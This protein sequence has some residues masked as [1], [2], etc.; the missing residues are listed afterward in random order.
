MKMT[1]LIMVVAA[2]ALFGTAI[3]TSTDWRSAPRDSAGIAPLP[4][5]EKQ[6][7]VQVYA[8]RAIN[9]R[10]WFAVH[11]W[12]A[13]K[14]KNADHYTVYQVMGWQ[15]YRTGKSARIETDLPDR[16]W[17]GAKPLLVSSLIGPAAESAIPKIKDA[18]KSYAYPEAYRLWPGPN[19]NTYISHIIRSVPEMG[20]ELPPNAIGKDWMGR[21]DIFGP[22]E[23]GTGYQ[24]SLLGALGITIGRA[25]GVEINI[26]GLSFGIDF[27]RPALKLPFVGRIGMTDAP[28]Q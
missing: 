8:A 3:A 7:V 27:M 12:I 21:G 19:S 2:I 20:V 28:V 11:T 4:T 17:F 14:E 18:A 5:V 1:I 25:E 23:T 15:L 13:T 24:L 9:W 22:S 10:G 6:A 16:Y 26:L